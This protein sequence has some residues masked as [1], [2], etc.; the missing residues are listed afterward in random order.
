MRS[1]WLKQRKCMHM[2]YLQH[3]NLSL[4]SEEVDQMNHCNFK[5]SGYGSISSWICSLYYPCC[6]FTATWLLLPNVLSPTRISIEFH[7]LIQGR[8]Q[9][10]AFSSLV[11][12]QLPVHKAWAVQL[13]Y[14]NLGAQIGRFCTQVRNCN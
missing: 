12:S 1:L 10:V 4:F 7:T 2:P 5:L 13:L 3:E 6:R 9:P 11:L 14:K 8:A